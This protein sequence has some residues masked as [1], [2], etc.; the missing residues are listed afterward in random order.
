MG[1]SGRLPA[2]VLR[3]DEDHVD[4]VGDNHHGAVE[5]QLLLGWRDVP[6]DNSVLGESVKPNE[7]VIR[8]VLIGR[9]DDTQNEA[10]FQRKLYVIRKQTHHAI[11]D[12]D[13]E[14]WQDFGVFRRRRRPRSAAVLH[15]GH[16]DHPDAD[17]RL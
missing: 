7:P 5:G 15:T 16:D 10:A 8:Q 6:C 11:W 1:A 13:Q 3:G 9:G 14:G 12:Y 17:G 2:G 4:E